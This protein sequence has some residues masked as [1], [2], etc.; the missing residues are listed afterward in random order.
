MK[1]FDRKF[2]ADFISALP[3]TP[4]VYF[5][6]SGDGQLIYIGKAKNLR[7]RLS[8]Y[9][10]A[11]RRK[12][13]AKM[14]SI[15]ADAA[16]IEFQLCE[17]DL[18]ASLLETELIQKHRPRWNVEGAFFFLYPMLG[19]RRQNE[20]T[21]FCYTTEPNRFPEFQFHGAYRS[22]FLTREAFFA[23]IEL[24]SFVGHRMPKRKRPTGPALPK[25]SY[26][27][28]FRRIEADWLEKWSRLLAGESIEAAEALVL[29]L[30]E[31]AGARRSPGK[32]QEH[33]N[34][35]RRFW[36]HEALPLRRAIEATN[37]TEFPV[38]QTSRDSLFIKSR[39]QRKLTVNERM[40]ASR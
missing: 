6:H 13:H 40:A 11:K 1:A 36:R 33:L 15:I 25:F 39:W 7:R 9:R 38:P 30:V 5:I 17:S 32:I 23:L 10:N 3:T 16:R 37:C 14:K 24:L 26:L 27:Y 4:G 22:R 34:S 18:A 21:S 12:K 20:I 29:A 8:Q 31:N 19:V 28:E 2:G 35:I